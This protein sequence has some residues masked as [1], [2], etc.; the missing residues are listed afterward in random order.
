MLGKVAMVMGLFRALRSGPL[1]V[2]RMEPGVEKDPM[3]G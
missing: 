1:S 3:G 2:Q